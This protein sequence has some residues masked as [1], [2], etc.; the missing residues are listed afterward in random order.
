MGP[1]GVSS[2][3]ATLIGRFGRHQVAHHSPHKVTAMAT[4]RAAR[5]PLESDTLA[6]R[7]HPQIGTL[8]PFTL[9][10]LPISP[11]AWNRE[12]KS[13]YRCL[14]SA[15]GFSSAWVRVCDTWDITFQ[16]K[17]FLSEG[18]TFLY[19]QRYLRCSR[20]ALFRG[21]SQPGVLFHPLWGYGL[22]W[23]NPM[24]FYCKCLGTFNCPSTSHVTRTKPKS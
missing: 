18:T 21:W 16:F 14:V 7:P 13:Q 5:H 24:Q 9:G 19:I 4:A 3:F 15:I 12:Y 8:G 17:F 6:G 1:N 20:F 22:S 23:S 2:P 11:S 10:W